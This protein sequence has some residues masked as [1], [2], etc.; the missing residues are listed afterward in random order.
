ML[1]SETEDEPEEDFAWA[2]KMAL[3]CVA[4]SNTLHLK[5]EKVIVSTRKQTPSKHGSL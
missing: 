3:N 1:N 2:R 4:T 5:S